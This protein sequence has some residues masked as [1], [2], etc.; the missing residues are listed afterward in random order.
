M[1]MSSNNYVGMFKPADFSNYASFLQSRIFMI[2][3]SDKDH[4][5]AAVLLIGDELL[6]GRTKDKNFGYI[7][8]FLTQMAIDVR[9]ARVVSDVREDIVAAL[10]DL[11]A[12]Y[13]YVFTTGGIGPTH[14]DITA[15]AVAAAFEVDIDYHPEAYRAL[16]ENCMRRGIEFTT[17]RKRMARVPEGGVLIENAVSTAPGFQIENVFVMAGVPNVCQAMMDVAATRLK[18]GRQMLSRTVKCTVGEGDIGDA[19]GE[20]QKQHPNVSIGSYPYFTATG[21]G[22]NLV[23]RSTDANALNIAGKAVVALVEELSE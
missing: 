23:V 17:A 10:N 7:A 14:D 9:E 1:K 5:T 22:T 8:E 3:S 13:T 20:L 19:L 6:T 21:F 16:E 2:T 4:V 12:R 15:D 18:S 11:R